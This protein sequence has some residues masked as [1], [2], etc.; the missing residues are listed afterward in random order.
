M[1]QQHVVDEATARGCFPTQI[2]Y[3]HWSHRPD[4]WVN[5]PPS[6]TWLAGPIV[7][8]TCDGHPPFWDHYGVCDDCDGLG[9]P[10]SLEIVSTFKHAP[11][12]Q[13]K[14]TTSP[15]QR[16][17]IIDLGAPVQVIKLMARK[18]WPGRRVM[19]A[20]GVVSFMWTG[21]DDCTETTATIAGE[22]TP[23]GVVYP[24]TVRS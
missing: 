20:D 23:G 8:E 22:P 7:C 24:I 18:L 13:S 16:H 11:S 10:S 15:R 4:E 21:P 19:E 1:T 17:G 3:E 6:I 5:L 9:Y 2:S 12:R 14:S